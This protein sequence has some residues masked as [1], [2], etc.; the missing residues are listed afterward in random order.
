MLGVPDSV[1]CEAVKACVVARPG[2]TVDSAEPRASVGV[3]RAKCKV[4]RDVAVLDALPRN[5][6]GHVIKGGLR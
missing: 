3:R 5:P 4:P 2:R 6:N 1:Y